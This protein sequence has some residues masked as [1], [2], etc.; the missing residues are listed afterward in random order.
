VSERST[1]SLL[2]RIDWSELDRRVSR[3]QRNRE[4]HAPAISLFRW[5]ARRPHSLIGEILDAAGGG[6]LRVSDPFSGGGTVAMEAVSRG[7]DVYAQDL[8][9]W[10]IAGLA[11][12]LDRVDPE[13]L[14]EAGRRWLD[15]LQDLRGEL[16]GTSCPQHGEDGEILTT[17]WVRKVACRG[18]EQEVHL[19]PYPLVSVA[20]RSKYETHGFYGC[21]AC[22]HVT[23]SRLDVAGRRCSS[24]GRSLR[25]GAPRPAEGSFHCLSEDCAS[26]AASFD[27][28]YCWVPVLVQRRC[29]SRVHFDRP[30]PAELEAI[31]SHSEPEVP[32]SL[33]TPIPV[34][35][36]TKRLRRAGL[37]CWADLY[38][39]RQLSSLLG[40]S[41][42]L[43]K[44]DLEPALAARLRLLVSGAGEM[45]A[46]LS[47][48]DRF[49][50]KAFEATAN[51]RFNL[52]PLAAETNL[53]ADRGRGTLERRLK[54]SVAAARW[55][56][57]FSSAPALTQSSRRHRRLCTRELEAPAL[58]RGS[59]ARQL[60]PDDSVDLVLT[61][62]PYFDDVQYAELGSLFLAWAQTTGL[63]AKSVRVDFRAEAVPNSTRGAGVDR[64]CDLLTQ[65]LTESARTLRPGGRV[66]ITFHNTSGLAWWALSRALGKAGL[67]VHALAVAHAENETDHAKRGRLAFSHDLI[68]ES[69]LRAPEGEVILAAE[70]EGAQARQLL[71]AGRTVA[72][73]SNA[74][75]SARIFRS[76]TYE[77]FA[78]SYRRH[79]GAEPS[80]Y[81]RFAKRKG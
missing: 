17:L 18:C 25:S 42:G 70:G 12:A 54:H 38:P 73:H 13:E 28:P 64:Y 60:L 19:Y 26:T 51:H 80:T 47:R 22:G 77:V 81:I 33:L 8:H 11:T 4:V 72:E 48:W 58:V 5:W 67:F 20:S 71:A 74:L 31:A 32:P 27:Q 61:D 16:Y 66:V 3:E 62:P 2:E 69:R 15:A 75:A 52:T 55:A 63:V 57:G 21:S 9:P 14:E 56:A 30:S 36:E 45:A 1:S 43:A 68:L 59:S 6:Q 49:Y 65:I 50:P 53:L 46:Y 29:G 41:E 40:A 44:L 23:R 10:A 78:R 35:I 76:H 7:I 24:C 37:R 79:L 34:G 39:A